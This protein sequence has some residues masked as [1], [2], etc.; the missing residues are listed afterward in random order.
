MYELFDGPEAQGRAEFVRLAL[1]DAGADYFDIARGFGRGRGVAATTA[2]LQS[3]GLPQ[4]PFAPPFLRDGDTLVG[5]VANI[6]RHL[7][8]NLDLAPEGEKLATFAHGMQLTIDDLVSE[9]A[10]ARKAATFPGERIVRYLSYFE[11]IVAR[12]PFDSGFCVGASATYVDL[13][14]FQLAS[15]L[16]DAFPRALANFDG[17]YPLLAALRR[18]IAARPMIA[19]YMECD[20]RHAPGASDVF[21]PDPA[22]ELSTPKGTL[23]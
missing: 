4:L 23:P 14:L 22:F 3:P 5:H 6:L 8:A 10:I 15:G 9:L 19:A 7:A 13:S 21:R 11:T 2:I 17:A 16:A 18:K 1:E 20:R 12:N